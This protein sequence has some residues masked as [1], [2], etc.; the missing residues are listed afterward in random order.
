MG[1]LFRATNAGRVCTIKIS[2]MWVTVETDQ[3]HVVEMSAELKLCALQ[4]AEFVVGNIWLMG[5]QNTENP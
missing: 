2:K 4:T 5:S 1:F 3:L